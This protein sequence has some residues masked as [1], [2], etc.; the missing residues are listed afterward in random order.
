MREP[1]S[2]AAFVR[3]PARPGRGQ[4]GCRRAPLP[5][6]AARAARARVLLRSSKIHTVHPG[7]FFF[8][9]SA[10]KFAQG[11]SWLLLSFRTC[12]SRERCIVVTKYIPY[13]PASFS[14]MIIICGSVAG[15]FKPQA[16]ILSSFLRSWECVAWAACIGRCFMVHSGELTMKHGK[17]WIVISGFCDP[18]WLTS[19]YRRASCLLNLPARKRGRERVT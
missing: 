11:F 10:F 16:F 5:G 14:Q 9:L 15:D 2:E 8:A 17:L 4:R 13:N 1:S 3:L 12:C 7:K 18:S 6:R 19:A